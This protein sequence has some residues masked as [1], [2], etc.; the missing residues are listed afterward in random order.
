MMGFDSRRGADGQECGTRLMQ[1][2][3][4]RT[5]GLPQWRLSVSRAVDGA[6]AAV[7]DVFR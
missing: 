3:M 1:S 4:T 5:V 6:V 7:G 2:A